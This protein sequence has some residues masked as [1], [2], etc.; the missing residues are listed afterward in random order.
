MQ[1]D[2]LVAT[3]GGNRAT[4]GRNSSASRPDRR[5]SKH[6]VKVYSFSMS[7]YWEDIGTGN[8]SISFLERLQALTILV[9]SEENDSMILESKIC[10]NREYRK[11]EDSMITWSE[12]EKCEIA[13]SFQEKQGCEEVWNKI[14]EIQAHKS[15]SLLPIVA[16]GG[17]IADRFEEGPQMI[18]LPPCE[19]SKLDEICELVTSSLPTPAKQEALVLAI[20]HESYIPKLIELFHMCED[21]EN[22]EGLHTLFNIVRT[23]FFLN[24][25]SLLQ[26]MFADSVIDDIIGCLEYDPNKPQ[27]RHREYMSKISQHKEVIPFNNPELLAKIHQTYKVQYIQEVILPTPSLFEENLM[28]SLNS[29]LMFNKADIINAIQEDEKFLCKLFA[30]IQDANT[31]E[32][33]FQELAFLLREIIVYSL[34]L[35]APDRAKFYKH[36][37]SFGFMVSIEIMLTYEVGAVVAT[38]VD[39][40]SSIAEY[41]SSILRDFI[42]TETQDEDGQFLNILLSLLV[43]SQYP[44]ID[45]QLVGLIKVLVDSENIMTEAGAPTAEKSQ[46]LNHFYKYSMHRLMAPLMAQTSTETISKDTSHNAVLLSHILD[47]LS[48]CVERHTYH[49]RNYVI[50]KNV[51]GRVLVL[52]TSSHSHLALAAVRFCRKIVGLR[53]EFYNR[54]IIRNNLLAPI[55][56][57]F[58]DQGQRYNLLNSAIIE[59]FEYIHKEKEAKSLVAYIVENFM[60]TLDGVDYVST[61]QLLKLRHEQELDRCSQPSEPGVGGGFVRAEVTGR[62]RR[63]PRQLDEDEEAWFDTDEDVSSPPDP[64]RGVPVAPKHSNHSYVAGTN[65]P[66]LPAGLH[67]ANSV[68]ENKLLSISSS[69]VDYDEDSDEDLE[70][71][72]TKQPKL[73]ST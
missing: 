24:K 52:L 20:E 22:M 70:D 72:P 35:E 38:A 9:R 49:I 60:S 65:S 25:I 40:L 45:V 16:E 27:A 6:R 12:D 55:V 5:D 68:P 21:L 28:S 33:Q 7:G 41:H 37:S 56:K 67:R 69:L 61:F 15:G 71:A 36:L 46:F 64:R 59:L 63:D 62:Y 42:L 57:F 13:I 29:F 58:V 44:E 1:K 26:L 4:S 2:H 39:I 53:D 10:P 8:V 43:D 54:Y 14:A 23:F 34:S 11:Q 19:L 51:L 18:Q 50:D 48:L 30:Q 47:I 73:N 66:R 32:G 17:S 3:V 31:S